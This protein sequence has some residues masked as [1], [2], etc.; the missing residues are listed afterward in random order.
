MQV[1]DLDETDIVHFIGF[2]FCEFE[3]GIVDLH[4]SLPSRPFRNRIRLINVYCPCERVTETRTSDTET[5]ETGQ[6][7]QRQQT[8]LLQRWVLRH[9]VPL[10]SFPRPLVPEHDRQVWIP[11]WRAL[12]EAATNRAFRISPHA[13]GKPCAPLISLAKIAGEGVARA[14]T[15]GLRQLW[16][17]TP[18]ARPLPLSGDLS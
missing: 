4:I 11:C 8:P 10:L 1:V 2:P 6:R 5:P 3:R 14:G 9:G 7:A 13:L 17:R 15:G 18:G 12:I 16:F